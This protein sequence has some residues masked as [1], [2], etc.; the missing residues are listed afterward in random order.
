MPASSAAVHA[1]VGANEAVEVGA[2]GVEGAERRREGGGVA[3]AGDTLVTA[4][5][6]GQNGGGRRG[7]RRDPVDGGCESAEGWA[8][9]S[10]TETGTDHYTEG[11]VTHGNDSSH[12]YPGE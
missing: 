11:K 8:L 1:G 3:G 10:H 7:G 2:A 4:Q 9:S 5:V 12:W 6:D